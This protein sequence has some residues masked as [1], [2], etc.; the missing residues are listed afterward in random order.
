LPIR[1]DRRSGLSLV[2]AVRWVVGPLGREWFRGG[3]AALGITVLIAQIDRHIRD[4]PA[5]S[6]VADIAGI[7]SQQVKHS[8]PRHGV[9]AR[10]DHAVNRFFKH[11]PIQPRLGRPVKAPAGSSCGK[12]CLRHFSLRR[13]GKTITLRRPANNER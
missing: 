7:R 6:G 10:R 5:R 13:L 2:G 8:P 3:E 9:L 11:R 4:Q 12:G 1:R